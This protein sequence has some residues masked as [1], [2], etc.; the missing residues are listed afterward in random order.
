MTKNKTPSWIIVTI[1]MTLGI[2]GL[3]VFADDPASSTRPAPIK[4]EE[5]DL[6]KLNNQYQVALRTHAEFENQ[7]LRVRLKYKIPQ[8]WSFNLDTGIFEAPTPPPKPPQFTPPTED[9]K[10]VKPTN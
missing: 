5:I 9:K 2:G 4:I 7:L 1:L 10:N 8:D 6:L 3:L